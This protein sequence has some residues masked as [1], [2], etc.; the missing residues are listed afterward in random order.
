[1]GNCDLKIYNPI[2]V[3]GLLCVCL[4]LL[5]CCGLFS[6]DTFEVNLNLFPGLTALAALS[7]HMINDSLEVH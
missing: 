6:Q 5:H 3:L 2:L 1:M 7:A 4:I